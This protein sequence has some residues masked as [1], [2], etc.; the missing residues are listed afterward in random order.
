MKS[1]FDLPDYEF[2]RVFCY[3]AETKF[4]NI[5]FNNSGE[6]PKKDLVHEEII[7]LIKVFE[8]IEQKE[9]IPNVYFYSLI[10]FHIYILRD[11]FLA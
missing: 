1:L 9:K 8:H 10:R 4:E 11:I 3:K 2:V 7:P 6:I 5:D